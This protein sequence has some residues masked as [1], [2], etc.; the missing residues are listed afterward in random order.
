[1]FSRDLFPLAFVDIQKKGGRLVYTLKD[2]VASTDYS[3]L[4]L[5]T[6]KMEIKIAKS[7]KIAQVTDPMKL[8]PF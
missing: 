6:L 5:K 1:L 8:R 4:P 7:G 2:D 3:I